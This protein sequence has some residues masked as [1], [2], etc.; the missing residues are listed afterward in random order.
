MCALGGKLGVLK[1]MP[2]QNPQGFS[3][4]EGA[5]PSNGIP[6]G[7]TGPIVCTSPQQPLCILTSGLYWTP[8]SL[9]THS[10]PLWS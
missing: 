5:T 3:W 7:P 4:L 9:S 10:L 1:C 8:Y 6:Q 2:S